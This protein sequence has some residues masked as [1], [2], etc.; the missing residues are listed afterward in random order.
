MKAKLVKTNELEAFKLR[1]GNWIVRPKGQLGTIGWSPRPWT[2]VNVG[3]RPRNEQQ[4][5]AK[6]KGE[7]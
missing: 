3:K 5:I 2:A 7:S 1:S 4:A 6:A